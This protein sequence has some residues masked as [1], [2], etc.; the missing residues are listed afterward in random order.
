M[1]PV[2]TIAHAMGTLRRRY[3][4]EGNSSSCE[5]SGIARYDMSQIYVAVSDQRQ[6]EKGVDAQ[7]RIA[8]EFYATVIDT[9]PT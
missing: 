2:V 8:E 3:F 4:S 5:P 7:R 6:T 9:A 1:S